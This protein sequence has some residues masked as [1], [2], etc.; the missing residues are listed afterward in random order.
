MTYPLAGRPGRRADGRGRR[1]PIARGAARCSS[2]VDAQGAV[3]RRLSGGVESV[4][5]LH[6]LV[7]EHL[8]IDAVSARRPPCP[9]G[10]RR[11]VEAAQRASRVHDLTRFMPPEG[12]DPRRGAVL[13]LFA[14]RATTEARRPRHRGELLLTERAHHMRSHPGQ[15]SFPGG[16]IDPGETAGRG[17]AA[18]GRRGD[19]ARPGRR[20][21]LR[22][23]ARAVAAA[24]QLRGDAGAG[25][26][27][28][29][30]PGAASRA[31]TRC[32]PSTTSPIAELLDPDAPHQRAAPAGWVGPGFLIG[33]R[34]GRHPVGLH[35]R[36]HR[37][38]VR[39]P[40]LGG[41]TGTRRGCV[42]CPTTCCKVNPGAP[43]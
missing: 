33:E 7:E 17:G 20:R 6:D 11:S 2:F 39:L 31:P 3:D 36:H 4:D 9:A 28:R 18:R 24:E 30:R 42:T 32:T 23:A 21:G 5:E 43:T 16:T 12:S 8:G 27:A 29:P 22:R 38:A 1:S 15:V 35:R 13:M 10:W 37:P 26:L 41:A 40:R 19:R 25:L 14:D 34:Q